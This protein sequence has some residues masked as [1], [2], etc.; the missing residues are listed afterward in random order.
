M[1]E[2]LLNAYLALLEM[3]LNGFVSFEDCQNIYDLL[4]ELERRVENGV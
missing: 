3:I 1:K 2:K 4:K